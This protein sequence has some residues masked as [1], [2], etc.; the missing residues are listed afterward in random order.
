MF[1]SLGC[2]PFRLAAIIHLALTQFSV[3]TLTET[4]DLE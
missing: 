2:Q 1:T 4:P 3:P